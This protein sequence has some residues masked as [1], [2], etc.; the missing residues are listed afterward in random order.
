MS[1]IYF[2][3]SKYKTKRLSQKNI[4]AAI[5]KAKS[6]QSLDS[7]DNQNTPPQ[8]SPKMFFIGAGVLGFISLLL[9]VISLNILN[10]WFTQYNL[11]TDSQTWQPIK[12]TLL[13]KGS[14]GS[15]YF[16]DRVLYEFSV[17]NI[18]QKSYNLSFS[19]GVATVSGS[20]GPDLISTLPSPG[21][22]I[23]V[24][25]DEKSGNSVLFSGRQYMN[26]LALILTTPLF[27]VGV[28]IAFFLIMPPG[29]PS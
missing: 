1:I 6:Q 4:S 25:F 28:F 8:A 10:H 12:G 9:F 13:K 29:F 27:F 26:Y 11:A 18:T 15:T 2:L 19:N 5:E 21:N 24:Y 23:T 7:T 22:E 16:N 20:S 3:N 17:N 14:Y